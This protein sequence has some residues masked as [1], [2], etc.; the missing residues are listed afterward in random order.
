LRAI[1]RCG[2]Y[3]LTARTDVPAR[4]VINEYVEIARDFF[5]GEEP[6]VVNGVLDRVARKRRP[7]EF[8]RKAA[9]KP[10]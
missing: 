10:V 1:L 6:G 2:V 4:A 5:G 3:E 9:K 8:G 7:D